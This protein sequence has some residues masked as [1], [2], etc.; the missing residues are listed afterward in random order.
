[1]NL[2]YKYG[3]ALKWDPAAFAFAG[4]TGDPKWFVLDSRDP[5]K[6]A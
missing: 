4:G 6:K 5:W 3:K 2:A 1:M